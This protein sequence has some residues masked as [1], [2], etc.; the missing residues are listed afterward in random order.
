MSKKMSKVISLVTILVCLLSTQILTVNASSVCLGSRIEAGQY[1]AAGSYLESPNGNYRFYY[2]TDGNAVIYNK[3]W[4]AIW[5]SGTWNK[6]TAAW[7]Q[8]NGNFEMYEHVFHVRLRPL[9]RDSAVG[10]AVS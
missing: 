4:K 2:Q 1:M 3:N 5:S 7:F 8:S 6:A 10:H 9:G